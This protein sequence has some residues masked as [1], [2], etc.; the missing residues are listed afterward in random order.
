MALT[1]IPKPRPFDMAEFIPTCPTPGC[2]RVM[3]RQWQWDTRRPKA[4][5]YVCKRVFYYAPNGTV[6]LTARIGVKEAA[7]E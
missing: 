2:G 4:S 1:I 3:L 7:S 6:A 5:C